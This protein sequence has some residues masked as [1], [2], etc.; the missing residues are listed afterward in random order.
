MARQFYNDTVTKYNTAIQMFPKSVVAGMFGFKK[1]E[2][3]EIAKAEREA[4]KID[5]NTFQF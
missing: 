3:L 2:L 5:S 1:R 4:V